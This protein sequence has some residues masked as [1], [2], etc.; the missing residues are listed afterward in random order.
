[1]KIKTL[2]ASALL[3]ASSA[4]YADDIF[5]YSVTFEFVKDATVFSDRDG[6][7]G[8]TKATDD[9]ITWGDPYGSIE[10]RSGLYTQYIDEGPTGTIA[11]GSIPIVVASLKYMNANGEDFNQWMAH[12]QTNL[13]YTLTY[14]GESIQL[15]QLMDILVDETP[16]VDANSLV[17]DNV[18]FE[19]DGAFV[20]TF[21]LGGKEWKF[22]SYLEVGPGIT[23]ATLV[24]CTLAGNSACLNFA[25]PEY[26]EKNWYFAFN[27]TAVP[28]PETYAMLLAGLGIVG[29][30]AR[31]RN[32]RV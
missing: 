15:A 2:V 24:E 12:T 27:I 8:S 7:A 10:E 25:I 21:T 22:T 30:V 4:A 9:T 19:K 11:A 3:L 28:E 31:R 14:N 18:I 16:N 5:S 20:R 23:E 17:P 26:S 29:M 6:N 32:R 1:L 13:A